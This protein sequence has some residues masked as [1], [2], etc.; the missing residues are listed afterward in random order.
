[1][2]TCTSDIWTEESSQRCRERLARMNDEALDRYLQACVY[3]T[4]PH[5]A[6]YVVPESFVIQLALTEREIE[7]RAIQAESRNR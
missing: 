6:W 7:R 1:M 3:V 4:T 5:T 2:N